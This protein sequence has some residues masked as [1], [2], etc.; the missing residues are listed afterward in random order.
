MKTIAVILFLLFA[1]PAY[2][3]SLFF[4]PFDTI[5]WSLLGGTALADIGDMSTSSS[6]SYAD[7][8]GHPGYQESNT[9]IDNFWGNKA[10][11]QI[12]YAVTFAGIFAGQSL[13]AWALP[14]PIREMALGSFITIGI[15]DINHNEAMGL[16]VSW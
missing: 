12:Q 13:I 3:D 2:A 6:I 9:L 16:R 4:Q 15:I 14:V 1:T 11:S 5:D 7:E 10:P 8:H